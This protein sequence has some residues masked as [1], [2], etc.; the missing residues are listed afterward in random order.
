MRERGQNK[1]QCQNVRNAKECK[2]DS[3]FSDIDDDILGVTLV[4]E[5]FNEF[6]SE[7]KG[8]IYKQ[9]FNIL[10]YF[11]PIKYLQILHIECRR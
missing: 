9:N 10:Q 7:G 11:H 8:D 5:F 6:V 2:T 4:S 1:W 3:V